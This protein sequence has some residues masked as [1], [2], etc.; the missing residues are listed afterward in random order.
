MSF[1]VI[2]NYTSSTHIFNHG[3]IIILSHDWYYIWL[4]LYCLDND[5]VI[6]MLIT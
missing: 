2:T 5:D 3:N 1:M 6:Q 4:I